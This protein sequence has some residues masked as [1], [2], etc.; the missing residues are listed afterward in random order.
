[1]FEVG[2]KVVIVRQGRYGEV[3]TVLRITEKRK[4][5]V[6]QF[7]DYKANYGLDGW[8]KRANVW[9]MTRIVP[10]TADIEEEVA[11]ENRIDKCREL[12]NVVYGKVSTLTDEQLDK[13]IL[14]LGEVENEKTD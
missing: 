5:V 13:V 1:M 4:D 2:K 8:E 6:V 11:H 7:S 9:S 3:G 10:L 14:I 12:F